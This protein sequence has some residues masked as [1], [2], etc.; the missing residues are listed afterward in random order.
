MSINVYN[1]QKILAYQQFF[2]LPNSARIVQKTDEN[3]SSTGNLLV[4]THAQ[5]RFA[6]ADYNDPKIPW[7]AYVTDAQ[8]NAI[9]AIA[10]D[11]NIYTID[12]NISLTISEKDGF[13]MIS[14][15]KGD[16]SIADFHYKMNFFYTT[17]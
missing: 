7:G 4:S 8:Y 10:R 16:T 9:I 6:N 14:A 3:A 17:K 5:Y 15:K 11:G 1:T 12:K 2:S 13:M